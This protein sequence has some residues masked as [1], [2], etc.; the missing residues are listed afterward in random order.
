MTQTIPL[1][2]LVPSKLN[3]RQRSDATAD[4]QL[5]AS[6]AERGGII[7]NLIVGPVSKP[8]GCFEVL[9]GGRRFRALKEL[10]DE[11]VLAKD[12][13]VDCLS[14]DGDEAAR[15]ETS[16]QANFQRL[17][18]NPAEECE[19]FREMI[20]LGGDVEGIARRFGLTTRFVE[21]RLRLADLAT[22]VFDA[23]REGSISLDMAKAYATRSDHARQTQVFAQVGS[24]SSY[25]R[26]TPDSVRRM[27]REAT[28][29][30]N[31]PRALLV[32]REAYEAAGGRIERDL[33]A[34]TSSDDQWVD[35]AILEGLARE[36]METRA[37]E[38]AADTNLGWI[39]PTL[40]TEVEYDI[41]RDLHE[42]RLP[43]PHLSDADRTRIDDLD[44]ELEDIAAKMEDEDLE[45]AKYDAAA[46][47]AEQL[48]AE[49]DAIQA[50]HI[51]VPEEI[52]PMVGAFL[53]LAP[54]GTTG[55]D[56]RRYAEQPIEGVTATPYNCRSRTE[57]PS[58]ST[59]AKKEAGL[60]QQLVNELAMQ[61]RDVLGAVIA[62]DT[63]FA[64]DL[65]IFLI[66]DGQIA[67]YR[68]YERA[69]TT[70]TAA[71]ATGPE[72][73]LK[74]PDALAAKAMA[75][76]RSELDDSWT[77]GKTRADR[78]DLFRLLPDEG[79]AGWLALGIARTLEASAN[80]VSERQ[81]AFHDHLGRLLA[82]DVAAWWRPTAENFFGR[83]PRATTL[84]ALNE[85][86]GP[87][88]AQRYA[89]SK[90]AELA[91]SCEKLF[92]GE[93]LTE[94]DVRDRA[95][96]W[97]PD[98][99]RFAEPKQENETADKGDPDYD[100]FWAADD[101]AIEQL[102]AAPGENDE[103]ILPSEGENEPL[104]RL[105]A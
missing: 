81:N 79:R 37:R 26:P 77:T 102:A 39:K 15:A 73:T 76:I 40:A 44:G 88:I 105:A 93:A 47:R 71:E 21:G 33:F 103:A 23:L 25:N 45:P 5:K 64:L 55:L 89:G 1:N 83:V 36:I 3:V 12:H 34:E 52:R 18:L 69:G 4:A 97:V 80:I 98:A 58:P 2:K 70:L 54:D 30:G 27:M 16:L 99:M 46:A 48:Q 8:K 32:G 95:T 49:M 42:V 74:M 10:A 94:A 6:I 100:A 29:T 11:G 38:A 72:T 86:G 91:A 85:I 43:E 22:I 13:P 96:T 62:R 35:M 104:G 57:A 90:K 78:F 14:I 68:D 41:Y 67:R 28:V 87:S 84:A 61:R 9:D 92:A 59:T 56:T 65:T 17:N 19:A 50:R 60:S 20:R 63:T 82:V 75:T 7:Q 66:A 101:D 53:V 31:D 24:S 51:V